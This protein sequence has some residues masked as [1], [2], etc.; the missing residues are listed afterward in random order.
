MQDHADVVT[1]WRGVLHGELRSLHGRL[2]EKLVFLEL[3]HRCT[4]VVHDLLEHLCQSA[5]A[6]LAGRWRKFPRE[7]C[8]RSKERTLFFRRR[9]LVAGQ[10]AGED[11][12]IPVRLVLLRARVVQPDRLFALARKVAVR[13]LVVDHGRL[14]GAIVRA[15]RARRRRCPHDRRRILQVGRMNDVWLRRHG[16]SDRE[17]LRETEQASG[18]CMWWR[19][20]VVW[21]GLKSEFLRCR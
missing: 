11:K 9:E 6:A 3:L 8:A 19:G 5:I 14:V 16:C 15:D 18:G 20:V 17:K 10:R 1:G 2:L 13:E 4:E 12:R 21:G 7:G